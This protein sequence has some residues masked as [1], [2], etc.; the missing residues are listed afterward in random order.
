M[1]EDQSCFFFFDE[2][3]TNLAVTKSQTP[4]YSY[5]HRLRN[6]NYGEI[7]MHIRQ[8]HLTLN[9]Q[10]IIQKHKIVLVIVVFILLWMLL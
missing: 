4:S 6:Q 5:K 1:H 7:R 2:T 3:R 8:R 9:S 10:T